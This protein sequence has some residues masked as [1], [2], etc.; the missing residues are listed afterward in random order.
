MKL[1]YI[2]PDYKPDN[3]AGVARFESLYSALS[4]NYEIDVITH[5]KIDIL[6]SSTVHTT[7]FDKPNNKHKVVYRLISE[8]MF[9][10]NCSV[11]LL[12]KAKRNDRVLVTPPPFLL[13]IF[14]ALVCRIRNLDLTL[15]IRDIYPDVYVHSKLIRGGGLIH[16]FLS[17]LEKFVYNSS[18]RIFTVTE[19]LKTLIENRCVNKHVKVIYNGY[20]DEFNFV[21]KTIRTEPV[22]LHAPLKVI[23]HG[24]FGVFQD[25]ELINRIVKLTESLPIHFTFMGFGSKFNRLLSCDRVQLVK[26]IERHT[27]A[28]YLRQFDV[29]ISIRTD[30]PISRDAFPVKI[31]EYVALGMPVITTPLSCAGELIEKDGLGYQFANENVSGIVDLLRDMALNDINV[32]DVQTNVNFYSRKYQADLFLTLFSS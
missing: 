15:D 21:R 13:S 25:V 28:N 29:G 9:S 11:I 8:V 14:V 4:T 20:S 16:R 23:M 18:T 17:S 3:N 5:S 30:E 24:N 12:F 31:F 7:I 22:S 32:N 27:V 1:F 10:I 6:D 19:P 26:P 2:T